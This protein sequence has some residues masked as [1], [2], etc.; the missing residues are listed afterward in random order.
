MLAPQNYVGPAGTPGIVYERAG[1]R[2]STPGLLQFK[3]DG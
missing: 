2:L 1:H 3:N